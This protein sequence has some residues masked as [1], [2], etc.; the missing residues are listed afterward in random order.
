MFVWI[1]QNFLEHLRETAFVSGKLLIFQLQLN[2]KLI[3]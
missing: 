3:T 1:L 2:L